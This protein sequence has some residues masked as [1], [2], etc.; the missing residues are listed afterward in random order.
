MVCRCVQRLD[1]S[2]LV[3]YL[4]PKHE[5]CIIISLSE[6]QS[7]LYKDYLDTQVSTDTTDRARQLLQHYAVLIKILAHPVGKPFNKKQLFKRF[8]SL[9]PFV[10]FIYST[11]DETGRRELG[12]V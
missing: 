6:K 7:A 10:T 8:S 2:V 1:Y 11:D 12:R 4:P 5:Y 3:P 9:F